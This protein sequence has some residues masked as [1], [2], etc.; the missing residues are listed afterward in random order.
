MSNNTLADD[1]RFVVNCLHWHGALYD[2][3]SSEVANKAYTLADGY[4]DFSQDPEGLHGINDGWDWSHIRDSS[5]NGIKRM[6]EYLR[7]ELR[8]V[9]AEMV[10]EKQEEARRAEVKARLH[11]MIME[12][13]A[14]PLAQMLITDASQKLESSEVMAALREMVEEKDEG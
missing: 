3:V 5:P 11:R 12:R 9:L 2:R 13:Q 4:G 14:I 1:R 6:A 8:P 7:K 10:A